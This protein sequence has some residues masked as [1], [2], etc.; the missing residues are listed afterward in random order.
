MNSFQQLTDV[1]RVIAGDT[2]SEL[3]VFALHHS[4][5]RDIL[6]AA[7][8]QSDRPDLATLLEPGEVFV[9]MAVIRE[10][11]AGAKSYLTVKAPEEAPQ[12]DQLA[13]HF[14][15]AFRRYLDLVGQIHTL[16]DFHAAIDDLLAPPHAANVWLGGLGPN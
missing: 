11:G 14:S 6:A 15:Q 12:V 5:R 1:D 4:G 10:S 13:D 2:A 7:L 8:N 9:D 16:H 3:T